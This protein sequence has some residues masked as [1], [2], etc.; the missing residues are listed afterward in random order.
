MMKTHVSKAKVFVRDRFKGE[1]SML[2]ETAQAGGLGFETRLE[3]ES[4]EPVERVAAVVRNAKNGCFVLQ[5]VR[6]PVW[7][8]LHTERRWF[9]P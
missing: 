9:C 1:G 3:L 7:S 8:G 2:R 6:N 5:N 4:N